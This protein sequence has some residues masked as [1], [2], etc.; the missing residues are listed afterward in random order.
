MLLVVVLGGLAVPATAQAHR[1]GCNTKKCDKRADAHWSR[2]HPMRSAVASFYTP[3]D[4]GGP[5]ACTGVVYNDE[6]LAGVANKTLPCGTLLMICVTKCVHV[7]VVDRGPYI[8]GREFDLTIATA[9]AI[10]FPIGAGVGTIRVRG[11]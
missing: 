3:H 11:G 8:P 2:R 5:F 6:S 7:R 1:R 4:S 9:R 10:G